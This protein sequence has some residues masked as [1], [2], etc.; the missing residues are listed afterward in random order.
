MSTQSISCPESLSSAVGF[1][2]LGE[3][4]GADVEWAVNAA[5]KA[6]A[7]FSCGVDALAIFRN[8]LAIFSRLLPC[9]LRMK[10]PNNEKND[11]IKDVD[12]L[13]T[14]TGEQSLWTNL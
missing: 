3:D 10:L 6:G 5:L 7:V 14:H 2:L 9:F 4:F 8:T 1:D 12:A 11:R 13:T